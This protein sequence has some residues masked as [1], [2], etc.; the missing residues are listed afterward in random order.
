MYLQCV[1]NNYN[2]RLIPDVDISGLDALHT[3]ALSGDGKYMYFLYLNT[4][5]RFLAFL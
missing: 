5:I 4:D 3:L 2:E 1:S